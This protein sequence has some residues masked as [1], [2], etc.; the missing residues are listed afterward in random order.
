MEI[1]T[2]FF[3]IYLHREKHKLCNVHITNLFPAK[4]IYYVQN[5]TKWRRQRR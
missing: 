1:P 5:K 2:I 3:S 4:V